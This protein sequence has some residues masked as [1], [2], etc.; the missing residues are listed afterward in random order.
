MDD[1]EDFS[2]ISPNSWNE[3]M[4][5]KERVPILHTEIWY[6]I[7]LYIDQHLEPRI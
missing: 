5:R 1:N 7:S 4:P 3:Q 2:C 6:G